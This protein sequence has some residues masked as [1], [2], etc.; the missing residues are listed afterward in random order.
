MVSEQPDDPLSQWPFVRE[1]VPQ[2]QEDDASSDASEVEAPEVPAP[3]PEEQGEEEPEAPAAAAGQEAWGADE[4]LNEILRNPNSVKRVPGRILP[5][6]FAKRDVLVY[7]Q[8]LAQQE[9]IK[10]LETVEE[11]YQQGDYE[12]LRE[13]EQKQPQVIAQWHQYRGQRLT[14]TPERAQ[15]A[16]RQ[17]AALAGQNRQLQRLNSIT[18]RLSQNPEA[19][20]KVNQWLQDRNN[21]LDASDEAL[22]E[23]SEVV[24]RALVETE[25]KPQEQPN[26]E[27]RR[28]SPRPPVGS[29]MPSG[30][31]DPYAEVTNP[32][33]LIRAGLAQSMERDRG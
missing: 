16:E 30:L 32:M 17:Q 26:Q 6:V 13:L 24:T 7:Q 15:E 21:S 3:A 9:I 28:R 27:Q 23:F 2:A 5:E 14:M 12:S 11:L 10:A 1:E 20:A 25:T 4:W 31:A 8:A 29:G 19:Q 22:D 33:E 18:A